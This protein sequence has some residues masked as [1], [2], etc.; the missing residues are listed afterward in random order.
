M[1]RLSPSELDIIA[2]ALRA[3]AY[4]EFFPDWE[5]HILFGITRDELQDVYNEWPS[6]SH[7]IEVIEC[8]VMGA[9]NNLIG[10]PHGMDNELLKFVPGGKP[11]MQIIL[12]H[13]RDLGYSPC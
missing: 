2:G 4:G 12:N 5:F 13:L 9:L 8:A 7:D 6:Q 1:D 11:S 10:Y 3:A